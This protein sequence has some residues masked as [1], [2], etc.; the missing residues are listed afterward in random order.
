MNEARVRLLFHQSLGTRERLAALAGARDFRMF[1]VACDCASIDKR[2]AV[3]HVKAGEK[4]RA[5]IN[6]ANPVVSDKDL[7]HESVWALIYAKTIY[8]LGITPMPLLRRDDGMEEPEKELG[9]GM[10]G[11]GGIISIHKMLEGEPGLLDMAIAAAVRHELGHVFRGKGHCADEKCIMQANKDYP[12]F[13]ERIVKPALDFCHECR[14]KIG[15]GVHRTML[16]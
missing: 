10:A 7:A 5:I 12:D 2:D 8:G 9:V 1:G 15:E 14:L 11:I 3:R 6:A 4:L 16:L 13:V